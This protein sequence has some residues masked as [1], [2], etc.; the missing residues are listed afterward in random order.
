MQMPRW[1]HCSVEAA[2][3]QMPRW[4]HCSVEAARV[5]MPRWIHYRG[6]KGA[7]ATLDTL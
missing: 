1:I 5:Q 2:R 3:V 6:S 7:N 4:I